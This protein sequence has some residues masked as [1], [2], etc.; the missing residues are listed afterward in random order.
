MSLSAA[1]HR[2]GG[3]GRRRDTNDL[4]KK[5]WRRGHRY[6]DQVAVGL[7]IGAGLVVERCHGDATGSI[8]Q[9]VLGCDSLGFGL[10]KAGSI[11]SSCDGGSIGGVL[12]VAVRAMPNPDIDAQT[13]SGN[14]E[15]RGKGEDESDRATF[16]RTNY[17]GS[18]SP[19]QWALHATG[20]TNR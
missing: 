9:T 1:S 19:S 16:I 8:D 13:K 12:Q 14:E 4:G 5:L 6:G 10:V 11:T 3:D 2:R 15:S 20:I 17:R 7:P 18:R